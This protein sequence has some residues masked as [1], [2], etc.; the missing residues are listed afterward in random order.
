MSDDILVGVV[1][2][3]RPGSRV[4]AAL[5]RDGIA[6][7]IEAGSIDDLV[8]ECADRRPHVVV[9]VGTRD[10]GPSLRS[11]ARS[12]PRTRLVA[13][14]PGPDRAVVRSA[15]LAGAD[16]VV[17]AADLPVTLPV[18]VRAVWAGQTVVPSA[19]RASLEIA[20]LSHRE[21][22]V[23]DLVA[24]GL[25]N[26][27]IADRLCVTEHTVKSHLG[28]LFTKLGVHSRS[29]AIAAHVQGPGRFGPSPERAESVHV[30]GDTT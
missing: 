16:G 28:S 30:N 20:E 17:V 5:A 3:P 4:T 29:E 11:L 12:L 15:L 27:Q 22:E 8:R 23:L 19:A 1:A 2:D 26:A 6:S 13:V 24:A 9:H 7:I 25:S 10:P 21:R 14:V 18:T